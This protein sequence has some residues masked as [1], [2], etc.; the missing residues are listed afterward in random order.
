[1]KPKKTLA[2]L[3]LVAGIVAVFWVVASV[4]ELFERVAQFSQSY[5]ALQLDELP[6]TLLVLSLGMAWYGWR[7]T[8]EAQTEVAERIRS[9]HT[10]QELLEHNS[11][12]L[13][14]LFTAEED[15]RRALARELHDDMGQTST[16]IRTE[17]AVLQRSGGLNEEAQASA[18]RIGDSA[19][20]LSNITRHMLQRLRPAVLDSM[21]L[22]H[23]LTSLCDNWQVSSHITCHLTVQDLPDNLND[24]TSVT[25][26]RIVQ[27]AL[28]NV[29]RH[30]QA[31]QVNVRVQQSDSDVVLSIHDNGHGMKDTPKMN[32]GFGLLGMQERVA[33]LA[34]TLRIESPT[35]RGLQ[36]LI[37]IPKETV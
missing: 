2:D 17:V 1:M 18:K 20:H 23:A 25:L 31:T 24:Y 30:S 13:Q 6:L 19:Q 27:E 5:E 28:T 8:L 14:R 10:V 37:R 11:D 29:A 35:G 4:T 3:L 26:Y 22:A 7:R 16:A 12:L 21:G 36:L 34:G 9:E 33:S 15:E 32:A